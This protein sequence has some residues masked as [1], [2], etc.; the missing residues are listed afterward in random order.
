MYV[1]SFIFIMRLKIVSSSFFFYLLCHYISGVF[2]SQVPEE[3]EL[4]EG[5]EEDQDKQLE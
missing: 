3:L 1:T 4:Q 2:V 5:E